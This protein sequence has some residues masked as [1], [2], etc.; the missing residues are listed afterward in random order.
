[1]CATS[2]KRNLIRKQNADETLTN[3]VIGSDIH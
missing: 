2:Y 3:V 1:M